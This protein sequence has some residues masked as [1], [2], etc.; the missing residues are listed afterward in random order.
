MV[1]WVYQQICDGRHGYFC[2]VMSSAPWA[3]GL[4]QNFNS[5]VLNRFWGHFSLE[6]KWQLE[7][8]SSVPKYR[9]IASIFRGR[10]VYLVKIRK[11]FSKNRQNS[12]TSR[13]GWR[14]WNWHLSSF[15][16]ALASASSNPHTNPC[17]RYI[18]SLVV[19]SALNLI[20]S[21]ILN[22]SVCASVRVNEDKLNY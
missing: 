14:M 5:W 20:L 2:T 8:G 19:I 3:Q 13:F 10:M 4:I 9:K 12:G 6:S 16:Y 11:H 21:I 18:P 1:Y 7:N 22:W 17:K 15:A